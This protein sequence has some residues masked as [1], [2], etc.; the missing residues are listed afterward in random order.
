MEEE[1]E[2]I[3]ALEK[4][5]FHLSLSITKGQELAYLSGF[6]IPSEDVQKQEIMDVLN[7]WLI[8]HTGGLIDEI[9]KCSD[10]VMETT[11]KVNDM[12][13]EQADAS[14]VFITSFTIAVLVHLFDRNLIDLV[15]DSAPLQITSDFI[16]KILTGETDGF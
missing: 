11:L 5:N 1:E 3:E 12:S 6:A 4:R 7:K 15:D 8:L 10:W 13:E 14:R 16:K 2:R 9:H